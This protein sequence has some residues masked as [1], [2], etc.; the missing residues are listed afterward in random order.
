MHRTTIDGSKAREIMDNEG[1][2]V[3]EV[4]R[5]MNVTRM[6]VYNL[7]KGD[8]TSLDVLSAF[9]A[10]L[11]VNPLDILKTEGFPDPFVEASAGMAT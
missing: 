1:L 2:S 11:N 4:S 5:R 6:T 8:N 7:L 3:A 10:A 9:A